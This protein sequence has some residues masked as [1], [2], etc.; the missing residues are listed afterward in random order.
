M[1]RAT[2]AMRARPSLVAGR[3]RLDTA[4]METVEGVVVK[5]GA[6]GLVCAGV[7]ERGLG[8]AVRVDDGAARATG[9]ALLECL[10]QIDVVRSE[11]L[12]ALEPFARP[13]VLGGGRPV[14][15]VISDVTLS[16]I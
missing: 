5:I 13:P 7:I 15:A 2:E 4:V 6:E 8:V 3:D 12:D 1:R 9:P 16:A 14:G 11:Q 10:R